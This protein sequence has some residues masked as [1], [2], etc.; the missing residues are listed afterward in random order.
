[1]ASSSIAG[2]FSGVTVHACM[3]ADELITSTPAAAEVTPMRTDDALGTRNFASAV[4]GDAQNQ[5]LPGALLPR[6]DDNRASW[7]VEAV[8]RAAWSGS[9]R[10]GAN[11]P[12]NPQ[13]TPPMSRQMLSA[14][15]TPPET[16]KSFHPNQPGSWRMSE[17][18]QKR[19]VMLQKR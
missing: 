15:A 16:P 4:S 13:P 18:K 6:A 7:L 10:G 3:A 9:S 1:M 14:C 17:T 11:T 8:N 2:G 5:I 12:V 19:S